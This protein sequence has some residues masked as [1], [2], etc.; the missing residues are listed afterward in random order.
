MFVLLFFNQHLLFVLRIRTRIS[1]NFS[2]LNL[3]EIGPRIRHV[4]IYLKEY[5]NYFFSYFIKIIND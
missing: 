2:L 3:L 5:L 4:F 1:F